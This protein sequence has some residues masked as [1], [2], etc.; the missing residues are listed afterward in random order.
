MPQSGV[1]GCG[2]GFAS[3]SRR[4][5]P[6]LRPRLPPPLLLTLQEFLGF[7]V[8]DPP[9]NLPQLKLQPL[10]QRPVL[11]QRCRLTALCRPGLARLRLG[12]GQLVAMLQRHTGRDQ[13]LAVKGAPERVRL[14]RDRQ[15]EDVRPE[16]GNRGVL[17]LRVPGAGRCGQRQRL[18][19]LLVPG[20]GLQESNLGVAQVLREL[21][22]GGVLA[23]TTTCAVVGCASAASSRR[24][25]SADNRMARLG[26][27]RG[28]SLPSP[29]ST[30]LAA[31]EP[32]GKDDL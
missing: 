29:G 30:A 9:A 16:P 18:G 10:R 5:R 25:P 20:P 26:G 19:V 31:Y 6:A 12:V 23:K 7:E 17:L 22:N 21:E 4:P 24:S 3:T 32:A 13:L 11:L 1:R 2:Y 28:P 27:G 15:V 8:P 14:H